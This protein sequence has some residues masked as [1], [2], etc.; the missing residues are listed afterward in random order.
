MTLIL[1]ELISKR[2]EQGLVINF[3]LCTYIQFFLRVIHEEPVYEVF[4]FFR[5]PMKFL[6]VRDFESGNILT[7]TSFLVSEERVS[8]VIN[9]VAEGVITTF[10]SA[11][12]F[13]RSLTRQ[14]AL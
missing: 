2:K 5:N 9:S 6:I 13:T 11:P 3:S 4:L 1:K 8:G 7:I 12:R 10:T 14:A